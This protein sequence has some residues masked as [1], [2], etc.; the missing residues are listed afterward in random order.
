[1]PPFLKQKEQKSLKICISVMMHYLMRESSGRRR[2]S[3]VSPMTQTTI[4]R[5][6]LTA[7]AVAV[8]KNIVVLYGLTVLLC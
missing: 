2:K 4:P 3:R 5:L 7:A 1:M 8:K 6:E